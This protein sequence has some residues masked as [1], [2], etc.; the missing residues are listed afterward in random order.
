MTTE[1]STMTKVTFI[2]LVFNCIFNQNASN[3]IMHLMMHNKNKLSWFLL[4]FG[5]SINISFIYCSFKQK[6]K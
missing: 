3:E 2:N 5:T 6:Q 1:T 4:G